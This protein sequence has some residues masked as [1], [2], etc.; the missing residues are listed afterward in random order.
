MLAGARALVDLGALATAGWGARTCAAGLCTP[1]LLAGAR[2]A[3]LR[4]GAYW[5]CARCLLARRALLLAVCALPT[6][7]VRAACGGVLPAA[8]ARIRTSLLLALAAG[9]GTL[10]GGVLSSTLFLLV[11]AG[12]DAGWLVARAGATGWQAEMEG[13]RQVGRQRH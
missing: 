7:G 8:G 6:G 11:R 2:A 9:R 5:R 13:T 1:L 3:G 4:R 12:L 10:L